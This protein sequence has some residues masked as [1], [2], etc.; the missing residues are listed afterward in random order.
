MSKGCNKPLPNEEHGWHR[1]FCMLLE[2]PGSSYGLLIVA[3]DQSR[4]NSYVATVDILEQ[5]TTTKVEF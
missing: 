5:H 1:S 4:I 2:D 3:V